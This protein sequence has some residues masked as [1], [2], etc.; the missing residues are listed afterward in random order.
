M[1]TRR[2]NGRTGVLGPQNPAPE[3]VELSLRGGLENAQNMVLALEIIWRKKAVI[4][5]IVVSFDRKAIC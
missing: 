2:E 3:P 1:Y 5:L 4:I